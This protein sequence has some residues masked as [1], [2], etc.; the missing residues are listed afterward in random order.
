MSHNLTSCCF[1]EEPNL[2][3]PSVSVSSKL[4]EWDLRENDLLSCSG[5]PSVTIGKDSLF[6]GTRIFGKGVVRGDELLFYSGT[7]RVQL[8]PGKEPGTFF[9]TLRTLVT[10]GGEE[11]ELWAL[12]WSQTYRRSVE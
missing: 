10:E 2:I 3:T 12:V 7:Q 8:S 4:L 6:L 11:T 5:F 9:V 1:F